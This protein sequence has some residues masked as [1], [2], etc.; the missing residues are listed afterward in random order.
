MEDWETET[1]A[2][3]QT[4]QSKKV[5]R[6]SRKWYLEALTKY[7]TFE[8]RACRKEYWYF[9][10]Y[11]FI[12]LVILVLIDAGLGSVAILTLIYLLASSIPKISVTVRRLH[13]VN[14]S[15]WFYLVSLLPFGSLLLFVKMIQEGDPNINQYGS[16]PEID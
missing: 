16:K 9:K 14:L 13:D 10:L 15:G 4:Q 7:A 3:G 8:G 1:P 6:P 11:N 5:K 2:I 12:I